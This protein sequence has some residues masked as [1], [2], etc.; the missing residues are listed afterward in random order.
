MERIQG[1][2]TSCSQVTLG[3]IKDGTSTQT[4]CSGGTAGPLGQ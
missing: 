1:C 3:A 4:L 2:P